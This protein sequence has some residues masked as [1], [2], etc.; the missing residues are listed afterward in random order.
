[1]QQRRDSMA[2]KI[3]P[4]AARGVTWE[5]SYVNWLAILILT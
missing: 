1:M 2:R 4:Q 3:R 5:I